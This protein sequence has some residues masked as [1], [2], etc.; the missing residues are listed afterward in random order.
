MPSSSHL[1][2]LSI[3]ASLLVILS[4]GRELPKHE[5]LQ[6]LQSTCTFDELHH[7]AWPTMND[8]ESESESENESDLELEL[9]PN[10]QNQGIEPA[11]PSQPLRY[12]LTLDGLPEG[13]SS[14]IV[15]KADL[16]RYLDFVLLHEKRHTLALQLADVEQLVALRLNI[17]HDMYDNE[18][19]ANTLISYLIYAWT[20]LTACDMDSQIRAILAS[21]EPLNELGQHT[22]L[23]LKAMK[24][25]HH[26]IAKHYYATLLHTDKALVSSRD[27][28]VAQE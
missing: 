16:L 3:L 9:D 12:Q 8:E 15:E 23:K 22:L 4:Q 10:T 13:H 25:Q 7:I 1:L 26:D 6:Q 11:A 2:L 19:P 5:S 21:H 27:L 24:R 14:I 20:T 17:A 18:P 28:L